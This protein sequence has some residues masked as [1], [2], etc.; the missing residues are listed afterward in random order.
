MATQSICSIDGCDNP[1]AKRGWCEKHYQRWKKHGDPIKTVRKSHPPVKAGDRFGRLTAIRDRIGQRNRRLWLCRC[2]C[3]T[4]R[5]F[6]QDHLKT[7]LAR[8]CGCYRLDVV[9]RHGQTQ[10]PTW[11]SWQSMLNRCRNETDRKHY[12]D[13]GGRGI[14]VCGRWLQFEN[15]LA[16][17][18]ERPKGKTLDR[19]D[20]DGGYEPGN[21]RWATMKEQNRNKRSSKFVM[22]RGRKMCLSEAM[23]LSGVKRWQYYAGI[24]RGMTPEQALEGQDYARY[25]R[26]TKRN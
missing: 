20:V 21:C 11:K 25:R 15:F 2:D 16:D 1:S 24:K 23:E 19:I 5:W 14:K 18:G 4:E 9:T 13:Y 22:Y 6:R 17:M 10:A 8:G 3:G 7:G 12:Q 26:R